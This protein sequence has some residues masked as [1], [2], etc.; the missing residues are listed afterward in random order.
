MLVSPSFQCARRRSGRFST[1]FA[2]EITHFRQQIMQPI[3]PTPRRAKNFTIE[4][5]IAHNKDT[6]STSALPNEQLKAGIGSTAA[7]IPPLQL[8][9]QMRDRLE[10]LQQPAPFFMRRP[11]EQLGFPHWTVPRQDWFLNARL[12]GQ[13]YSRFCYLFCTIQLNSYK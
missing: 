10:W 1:T 9:L 2:R 4:S 11:R 6:A 7:S 12:P 13:S 3:T 8:Y 5:L